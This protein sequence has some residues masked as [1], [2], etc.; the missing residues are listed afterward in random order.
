MDSLKLAISSTKITTSRKQRISDFTGGRGD[1]V[2]CGGVGRG[3]CCCGGNH[4]Q[5]KRPY[6]GGREGRGARGGRGSSDKRLQLNN[7]GN[8]PHI[9]D[10]VENKLFETGFYAKFWQNR[11]PDYMNY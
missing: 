3:C 8:P 5:G 9:I 2:G 6:K 7:H 1:I 11:R 10:W 4:Y